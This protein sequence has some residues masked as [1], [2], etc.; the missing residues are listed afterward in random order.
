MEEARAR[1]GEGVEE[2]EG[3]V[4][5]CDRLLADL[6]AVEGLWAEARRDRDDRRAKAERKARVKAE[7]DRRRQEEEKG[8]EELRKIKET[9]KETDGKVWDPTRKMYVDAVDSS[10]VVNDSWRDR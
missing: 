4:A 1:A 9:E 8:L 2:G 3:E 10:S 6:R 7:A 5:M